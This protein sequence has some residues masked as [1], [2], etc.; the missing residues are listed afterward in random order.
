[1][2]SKTLEK[3]YQNKAK[4]SREKERKV[5]AENNEMATKH[6]IQSKHGINNK[7]KRCF[8]EK[9]NKTEN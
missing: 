7:A 9:L 4:E 2:Q 6:G 3:D 1:M 5:R 8:F